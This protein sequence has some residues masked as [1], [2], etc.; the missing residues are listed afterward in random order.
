MGR[1]YQVLPK[2]RQTTHKRGVVGLMRPIFECT[3]VDLE[4]FYY[5][6][7]LSENYNV[8]DGRPLLLASLAVDSIDT[9]HQGS[10]SVGL[11]CHCI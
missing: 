4:E 3:T 2:G 10:S 11:I 1:L 6:M 7:P 8:V 9:I 5:S